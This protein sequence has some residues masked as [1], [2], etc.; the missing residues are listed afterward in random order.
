VYEGALGAHVFHER[1]TDAAC[2]AFVLVGVDTVVELAQPL[3]PDTPL[4]RDLA[5][6]GELPHSVTWRVIDLDAVERHLE[7][8]GVGVGSR[9]ADTLTIDPADAL[10]AVLSFTTRRIP[11]DP[12]RPV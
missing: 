6:N 3:D 2:H 4:G 9:A 11:G 12:R 8:V 7:E 1:A 10:G 5:A